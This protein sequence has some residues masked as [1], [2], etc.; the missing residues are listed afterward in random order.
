MHKHHNH[1]HNPAENAQAAALPLAGLETENVTG[2]E[3]QTL[4]PE[5]TAPVVDAAPVKLT[6]EQ[7]REAREQKQREKDEAAALKRKEEF[8][9]KEAERTKRNEE[10]AAKREEERKAKEAEKEANRGEVEA[11]RARKAEAKKAEQQVEKEAKKAERQKAN[12]AKK[13]EK[14]AEKAKAKEAEKEAREA[15]KLKRKEEQKAERAKESEARKQ[16]REEAKAAEVK[17][18]AEAKVQR[19]ADA[20]AKR[21]GLKEREEFLRSPAGTRRPRATHFVVL[22]E[23]LG[24]P[25]TISIRGKLH[26]YIRENFAVGEQVSIDDLEAVVKPMLYGSP[27]RSFLSKLELMAWVDLV[28]VAVEGE[29]K[30]A[31]EDSTDAP[32]DQLADDQDSDV[33]TGTEVE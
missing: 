20:E 7:K 10:R 28:H 19:E 23:G 32:Q 24:K 2:T 22:A 26:S 30:N 29:D 15:D 8:E 9:R 33:D 5:G 27:I 14:Q 3:T 4:A 17:A 6:A 31:P 18:N 1:D 11:E 21:N 12:E 25:Q 13:A 16:A